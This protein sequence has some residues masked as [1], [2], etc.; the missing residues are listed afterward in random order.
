M[1]SQAKKF[2]YRLLGGIGFS[3]VFGGIFILIYG[4]SNAN[5][6]WGAFKITGIILLT[7]AICFS[8]ISLM[9]EKLFFK[10][11]SPT[12]MSYSI[13]ARGIF[14]LFM[15]GVLGALL[16]DGILLWILPEV[17][18][19]EPRAFISTV[20]FVV[21]LGSPLFLY[22]LVKELWKEAI[23]QVREKEVAQERLE[24]ELLAAQ[25]KNLQSQVNPHFLFNSLNSIAALIA[26]D[27]SKAERTVEQLASLFRYALE[28]N[29]GSSIRLSDELKIIEDYL[30][31][32]K[33]RFGDRLTYTIA[34]D[35]QLAEF[36]VPPLLL[37][38]LVEN[39]IKHG[40]GRREE[41]G[42]ITVRANLLDGKVELLVENDGPPPQMTAGTGVGLKNLKSRGTLIYG[43]EFDC[44]LGQPEP[45]RTRARL[46]LPS[47][48]PSHENIQGGQHGS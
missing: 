8:L 17:N 4:L 22:Q 48:N 41:S 40:I 34:L 28:S 36:P 45:G 25:L 21:F 7:Y 18:L 23:Q 31:I 1:T 11:F 33:V 9:L 44:E 19:F 32:E 46:L 47:K 29:H 20:F 27:P 12:R 14:F 30:A 38:P 42:Q 5:F 43:G 16:S 39:A 24:K 3:L 37:Q 35:P 6:P 26:S 2:F 10:N 15:I 13:I